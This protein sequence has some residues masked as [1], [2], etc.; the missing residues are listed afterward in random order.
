MLYGEV[1]PGQIV[2]VDV[3]GEGPTRDLHLPG[4]EGRRAARPAAVRDGRGR[5]VARPGRPRRGRRRD[6]RPDRRREG[7]ATD[8]N[9]PAGPGIPTLSPVTPVTTGC[10]GLRRVTRVGGQ[11][12]PWRLSTTTP[13]MISSR[14]DDLDHV[15]PLAEHERRRPARCAAVPS[16]DHTAYATET[17]IWRTTTASS[18]I[19]SGVAR[20]APATDQGRSWKPAGA[21][22]GWW[23]RRPRRRWRRSRTTN[24]LNMTDS[25]RYDVCSSCYIATVATATRR[26]QTR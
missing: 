6:A 1:G 17:D 21:A 4:P 15:E 16:P 5:A 8:A 24:G 11:W 7:R 20:R 25:L 19:D 10:A 3:E 23:W 13:T 22:A 14:A 2:L 18:Q 12:A 9:E 26:S